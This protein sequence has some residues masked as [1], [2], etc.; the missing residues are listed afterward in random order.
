MTFLIGHGGADVEHKRELIHVLDTFF[1]EAHLREA[2]LTSAVIGLSKMNR[3]LER[4]RSGNY[5]N[6]LPV[7]LS[8]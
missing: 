2:A 5:D 4:I 7:L 6:W 1:I 8:S 3:L